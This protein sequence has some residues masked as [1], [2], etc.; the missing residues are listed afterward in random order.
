MSGNILVIGAGGFIGRRVVVALGKRFP[1]SVRAGFRRGVPEGAVYCDLMDPDGLRA[2]MRGVDAVVNCAH[3]PGGMENA[4]AAARNVAAA[5]ASCGVGKLIYLS[6][7]A[8]YGPV[9]GAVR[10]DSPLTAELNGYSAEKVAA[11]EILRQAAGRELRVAILRPA[12][13]YGGGEPQFFDCFVTHGRYR[14]LRDLGEFGMGNANLVHVEDLAEFCAFLVGA[15]LPE[16]AIANVVGDEVP[17]W[18]AYFAAIASA[19][20]IAPLPRRTLGHAAWERRRFMRRVVRKLVSKVPIGAVRA[21]IP[22][23]ISDSP[24]DGCSQQLSIATDRARELGFVSR[25]GV[26]AGVHQAISQLRERHEI[27]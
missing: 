13:V 7:T 11:E 20:G 10:E 19:V 23:G 22:A 16:L 24:F 14:Q 5:A 2:A 18:N 4:R 12:L 26:E 1:G 6:S 17:T 3:S 15:E 9:S 8:V 21:S 25:F 27:P